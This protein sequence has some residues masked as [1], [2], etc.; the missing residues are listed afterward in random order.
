MVF[1]YNLVYCEDF[2]YLECKCFFLSNNTLQIYENVSEE[3]K[4]GLEWNAFK[5]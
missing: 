2:I 4:F 5:Q 1:I 3:V